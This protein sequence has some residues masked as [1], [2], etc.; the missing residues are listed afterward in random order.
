MVLAREL[1]A[2]NNT[3]WRSTIHLLVAGNA[4]AARR[5]EAAGAQNKKP[6]RRHY[7]HAGEGHAPPGWAACCL[8]VG[9]FGYADLLTLLGKNTNTKSRP[10]VAYFQPFVGKSKDDRGC[11]PPLQHD[12]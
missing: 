5:Q 9:V 8:F 6:P 2:P 4:G 3:T 10:L 7:R 1:G 12:D 11:E